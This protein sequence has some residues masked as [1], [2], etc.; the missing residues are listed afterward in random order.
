MSLAITERDYG[1]IPSAHRARSPP[2]APTSP[3]PAFTV[4]A[5]AAAVRPPQPRTA[6]AV[7]LGAA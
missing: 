3:S 6:L 2:T 1:V 5:L 7:A 4:G